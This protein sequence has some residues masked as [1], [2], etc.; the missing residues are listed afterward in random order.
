MSPEYISLEPGIPDRGG[1]TR[2]STTGDTAVGG[3]QSG[4]ENSTLWQAGLLPAQK[5]V[6]LEND[7]LGEVLHEIETNSSKQSSRFQIN[8]SHVAAARGIT[9][10]LATIDPE[11][12]KYYCVLTNQ[13]LP[14]GITSRFQI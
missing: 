12:K 10:T 9:E 5:L 7:L 2:P 8:E 11:G 14:D 13:Q 4:W 3:R 6:V 1:R